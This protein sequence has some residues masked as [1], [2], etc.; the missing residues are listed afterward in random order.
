LDH[1]LYKESGNRL[2]YPKFFNP[3]FVD[4]RLYG[5]LRVL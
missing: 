5:R 2:L 1:L 4:V 3:Y